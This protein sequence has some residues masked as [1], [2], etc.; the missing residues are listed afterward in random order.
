MTCERSNILRHV[1]LGFISPYNDDKSGSSSGTSTTCLWTVTSF[2]IS[3]SELIYGRIDESM[4]DSNDTSVDNILLRIHDVHKMSCFNSTLTVYDGVP[5]NP[6]IPYS[7]HLSP[8]KLLGTL[9]GTGEVRMETFR[10]TTGILTINYHGPLARSSPV[11]LS[12]TNRDN[13]FL[14]EFTVLKCPDS[15]PLPFVCVQGK[16]LCPVGLSGPACEH[17]ICPNDCNSATNQGRC[18]QVCTKNRS[19]ITNFAMCLDRFFGK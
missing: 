6:R 10:S 4:D 19:I 8:F 13:G 18:D 14:A 1:T 15:C 9:C 17:R 16:C 3:H 12:N 5:P 2:N 11:H 7:Y